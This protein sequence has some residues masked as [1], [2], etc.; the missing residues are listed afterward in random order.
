[1]NP[2]N[3]LTLLPAIISISDHN[4]QTETIISKYLNPN[5]SKHVWFS[6]DTWQ[7]SGVHLD[8]LHQAKQAAEFVWFSEDS[9]DQTTTRKKP[10]TTTT[11]T[12]T[13]AKTRTTRAARF[14]STKTHSRPVFSKFSAFSDL[15]MFYSFEKNLAVKLGQI[16]ISTVKELNVK[17]SNLL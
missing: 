13:S 7:S 2:R 16:R 3:L 17:S 6:Q 14:M 15:P 8:N 12:T 5:I 10:R 11:R 9:P 1:M 4:F